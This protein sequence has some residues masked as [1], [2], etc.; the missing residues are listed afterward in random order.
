MS[1]IFVILSRA[2]PNCLKQPQALVVYR[3]D[4]GWS[5]GSIRPLDGNN[6]KPVQRQKCRSNEAHRTQPNNCHVCDHLEFARAF[7]SYLSRNIQSKSLLRAHVASQ[8]AAPAKEVG[9][10]ICP[11]SGEGIS[12]AGWMVYFV[13]NERTGPSV[14][15]W[16]LER[17]HVPSLGDAPGNSKVDPEPQRTLWTI[18]LTLAIALEVFNA[19]VKLFSI[20]MGFNTSLLWKHWL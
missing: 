15:E 8:P 20:T 1:R 6:F 9:P 18:F 3:S 14:K 16:I 5:S 10:K 2:L 7:E 12:R 4:S 13:R 17:W 19:L 11:T